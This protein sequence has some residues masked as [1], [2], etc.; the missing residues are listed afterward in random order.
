M[1]DSSNGDLNYLDQF[2]LTLC[3]DN[4]LECAYYFLACICDYLNRSQLKLAKSKKVAMEI[5]I[6][7]I[8]SRQ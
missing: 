4:F 3:K 2:Q 7:Q 5:L 1:C 6:I 8:E